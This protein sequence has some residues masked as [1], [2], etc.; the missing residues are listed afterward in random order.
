MNEISNNKKAWNQ[1]PIYRK[2]KKKEIKYK[3]NNNFNVQLFI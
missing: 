1:Y 2:R 3:N